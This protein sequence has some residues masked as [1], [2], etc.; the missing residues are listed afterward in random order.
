MA[1]KKTSPSPRNA[2]EKAARKA[3]RK[4]KK[5]AEAKPAAPAAV[6]SEI[7]DFPPDTF[8]I[9]RGKAIQQYA[10]LEQS[11]CRLFGTLAGISPGVAAI[12]FFKITSNDSRMAILEKLLTN[13]HELGTCCRD[14]SQT[15][16]F[17]VQKAGPEAPSFWTSFAKAIRTNDLQRN[18][19]VHWIAA[20]HNLFVESK[21]NEWVLAPMN[22]TGWGMSG[23][24]VLPYNA[25]RIFAFTEKCK[26][27]GDLCLWISR[28]LDR[29]SRWT[30]EKRNT[31]LEIFQRPIIDPHPEGH[32]LYRT[33]QAHEN[34][35]PPSPESP[36]S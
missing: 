17:R 12:I 30:D 34:Q 22:L 6:P 28:F 36:S 8:W 33:P 7:T 18:E 16:I 4:A 20:P 14:A 11:L 29:Q 21:P 1:K 2:Q 9:L 3:A 32:P 15:C 25:D 10:V 19:I 31:W 5:K 23:E 24:S 26:F 35:H 27:L 13:K